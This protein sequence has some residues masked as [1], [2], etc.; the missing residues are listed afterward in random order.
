MKRPTV[1][2]DGV[3]FKVVSIFFKEDGSVWQVRTNNFETL[4]NHT[5]GEFVKWFNSEGVKKEV[6]FEEEVAAAVTATELKVD[7]VLGE[8]VFSQSINPLLV[9]S[10]KHNR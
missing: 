6:R 8:K 1:L 7:L 9:E 3:A 10:Q 4:T 5:D 2:V